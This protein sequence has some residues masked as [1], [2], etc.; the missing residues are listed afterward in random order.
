MEFV[1]LEGGDHSPNISTTPITAMGCRQCLPLSV[2]QLKGKHCRNGVVNTFG[3]RV[4]DRGILSHISNMNFHCREKEIQTAIS[5]LLLR[6]VFYVF[7]GKKIL[8]LFL[9]LFL[10][11]CFHVVKGKQLELTYNAWNIKIGGGSGPL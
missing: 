8:I 10:S 9:I 3:Y 11:S 5:M 1:Q 7:R 6:A 4:V 2:V